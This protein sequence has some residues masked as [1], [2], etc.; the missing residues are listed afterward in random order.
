[1]L[2]SDVIDYIFSFLQF[3]HAALRQCS[4]AHPFL[5]LLA[6]R[7]L[8]VYI[9]VQNY[10]SRNHP[11]PSPSQILSLFAE[12]PEIRDNVVQGLVTELVSL[13]RDLLNDSV[14]HIASILSMFAD[15]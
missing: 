15:V 7:H 3:D 11:Q 2:D 9:T 14:S 5:A 4:S 13:S 12:R 6:Q 8:Y 1:M 10:P